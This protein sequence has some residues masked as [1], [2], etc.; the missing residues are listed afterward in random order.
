[1]QKTILTK[2]VP[3]CAYTLITLFLAGPRVGAN[4]A[5][6]TTAPTVTPSHSE[7][8]FESNVGQFDA[9]VDFVARGKGYSVALR[10]QPEITLRRISDDSNGSSE[11]V[12]LAISINDM[13]TSVTPQA[14]GKSAA[15]TNYLLGKPE[16]WLTDVPNF[17]RVRYPAILPN[18]DVEYYGNDGRLE[19]DFVVHPG[20]DPDALRLRFGGADA[21]RIGGNGELIIVLDGREIVQS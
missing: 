12:R 13:D 11:F 10:P 19:Y 9:A 14:V 5:V 18:V 2:P 17:S 21:V 6:D 20:G 3:V 1:M 4:I 8:R 16:D 15:H 7:L